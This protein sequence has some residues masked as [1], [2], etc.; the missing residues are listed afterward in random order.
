V[1]FFY[2]YKEK[3]VLSETAGKKTKCRERRKKMKA[4]KSQINML[5]GSLWDKILRFALPL[6][7]TGILQ[8][9][10]NAADIAIVGRFTGGK[11]AAAMAA[12][13]A[14][15]PIIGLL[16]NFFIGIS[17]GT[18]VLIANSVGRNDESMIRKA[19]HTSIVFSVLGGIILM[20]FG[21]L[22]A[23]RILLTQNV[24]ADV[25]PLAVL[26]FK[27]YLAG[28]PIILLYNFE[29][30]VFR[31]IG[32]T[33]T[34]L[35]VLFLSG[36]L[37]VFFN[38]FF[39]IGLHRTVDGVAA[40]TVISNAVSALILFVD[41]LQVDSVVKVKMEELKIDS[42]AL[43][44]ILRIGIPAGIQAAVFAIANI[45][46]QAA[47]NSL[48]VIVMAASSAALNIQ[49]FAYN[50]L[51]SF[52]QACTTFV[53]QN[54]GAGKITRCKKIIGLCFGEG[55][56]ALGGTVTIILLFG[57][58]LLAIFNP[59]VDVVEVGYQRLIIIFVSYIFTLSY[60]VLSGYLRGFGI[61]VVPALL[62]TA[63]IC[64]IR[65]T[66]IYT[67]FQSHKTYH[68]IMMAYPFSLSAT[69]VLM[70]SALFVMRPAQRALIQQEKR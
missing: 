47:I 24:P 58:R 16:L 1:S 2:V 14:N 4:K 34:P 53:G 67:V 35:I 55:I 57:R 46:I 30:A 6:A 15:T 61:S 22:M 18:N 40:A 28:M 63:G 51:N 39:V 19:V 45:I 13:G 10:F 62:T 43:G 9:F 11:G 48:G 38:L 64:G 68:N 44:K 8:Q 41:L 3:S 17:L 27:I 29:A 12:V 59:A 69:A 52:S 31:G 21:E 26:Y 32:N 33:R 66:W 37:N 56:V 7:A 65:I 36:I 20:V 60:E 42:I 5:E 54:F 49:I 25:L 50:V 70:L 23:E